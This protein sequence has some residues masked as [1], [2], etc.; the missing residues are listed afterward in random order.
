MEND[1][2]E[3]HAAR[4]GARQN[5]AYFISLAPEEIEAERPRP[6]IDER[7]RLV[8]RAVGQHRQDRTED[9]VGHGRRVG[10]TIL[11]DGETQAAV[12]AVGADLGHAR[13]ALAR[14]TDI[15]STPVAIAVA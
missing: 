10:R 3:G 5:S 7:D 4:H 6:R 14:L 11:H 1:V 9:L 8:E 15:A 2:V 12:I 13:A